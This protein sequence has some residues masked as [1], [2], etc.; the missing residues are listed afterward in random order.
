MRL[1]V[2]ICIMLF[3]FGVLP[4]SA[5]AREGSSGKRVMKTHQKTPKRVKSRKVPVVRKRHCW[6]IDEAV[7]CGS[8]ESQQFQN[9]VANQDGLERF[10]DGPA[11]QRAISSGDLVALTE[12]PYMRLSDEHLPTEYR[13][14]RPWTRLFLEEMARAYFD[15]FEVPLQVNSAVRTKAYQRSLMRR[16]TNAAALDGPEASSHMTGATVDIAKKPMSH[17]QLAWARQYLK[18]R[19]K[20]GLIEATE[21]CHQLVFHVMVFK[22]KS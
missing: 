17:D 18:G 2:A 14:V 4:H 21:E 1:F 19:E 16:N 10:E 7:L 15:E 12:S 22:P 3:T 8:H 20:S 9:F 13:W 5:G 11:L 6:C